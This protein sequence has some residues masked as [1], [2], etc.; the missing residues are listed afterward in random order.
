MPLNTVAR[1]WS[2]T[3]QITDRTYTLTELRPFINWAY[4]FHAWQMPTR[5]ASL[6][7]LHQCKA[8]R[9]QWLAEQGAQTHAQASEAMKLMDDA[10]AILPIIDTKATIKARVGLFEANSTDDDIWVAHHGQKTRIPCLRQQ[11]VTDN[12]FQLCLADYIRPAHMGIPDRIGI[13]ATTVDYAPEAEYPNDPYNQMLAQTLCDRLAEA[14]ACLLHL[15]V[16]KS[17]W[18]YAPDEDLSI[19]DLLLERNQGIRPAVG[20]P[21]LPDQ[22][23]NFLLTSIIQADSLNITLTE[24]GAML[25]HASTCGLIISH[26]EAHYFI[27]GR[28]DQTQFLDYTNR[29]GLSADRMRKFLAA[30]YDNETTHND[31]TT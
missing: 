31:I 13:F 28:I 18:A 2:S 21:S 26:P 4:F 17:I 27:V 29:R 1:K 6:G 30:C 22:S 12:G 5:Y 15:E 20:Y 24:N 9:T 19:A 7:H 16:R 11:Q 23:I 3:M 8:C 14:A 25:P 10:L